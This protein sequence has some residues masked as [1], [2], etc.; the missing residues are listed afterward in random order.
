L[1]FGNPT[2]SQGSSSIRQHH[3]TLVIHTSPFIYEHTSRVCEGIDLGV[4]TE[5][6]AKNHVA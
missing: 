4:S 1:G 2:A 6:E 3:R 5:I